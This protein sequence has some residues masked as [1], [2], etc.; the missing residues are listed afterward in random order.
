MAISQ[1]SLIL[2]LTEV[3]VLPLSGSDICIPF[4]IRCLVF[5]IVLFHLLLFCYCSRISIS[6]V[7]Q[8]ALYGRP[9][10]QSGT[11]C[12]PISD[13]VGC[14]TASSGGY[15]RHFYSDSAQCELFLTAPDRNILTYLLI[16]L[17]I[18]SV[19]YVCLWFV[20]DDHSTRLT[21]RW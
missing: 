6:S 4:I 19:W 13:Y 16:Y 14:H 1:N 11:V 3:T 18:S 8:C 7:S 20:L 12:R 17:L 10:L 5:Y 2:S 21:V 15:W 9:M